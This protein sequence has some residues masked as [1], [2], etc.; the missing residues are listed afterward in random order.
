MDQY[1][2]LLGIAA[3]LF[4]AWALSSNKRLIRPR[5]IIGGVA[6]QFALAWMFLAFPPLVSAF[7]TIASIVNSVIS[8]SAAGIAFLFGE[9]QDPEG[10]WG[11]IFAIQALPIIIYFASLMAI[12]YYVGVMQRVVAA[13]AWVLRRAVGVSGTEA[14][15]MAA[16]VF[17]GQTEAPLCVKPYIDRMTRSQLMTLMVG[18]FATIAG[19]VLAA[20]V[21]LLGGAD[22]DL[23]VAYTRDLMIA[24]VMSAPAALVIAKMLIPDE[25]DAPEESVHAFNPDTG[26]TNLLD[27]AAAGA[28]DGMR[29]A[30][31]VG[32]MLMAFVALIALVNMPL[33][34]LGGQIGVEHLSLQTILGWIFTPV[35]WLMGVV[36]SDCQ[37]VGSFLGEKLVATE[38]VA[39]TSL[40]R[41]MS[42][43]TP[44]IAPRSAHISAYALCGFANFP[45]LAI[46]IGGLSAIAPSRR[47][48]FSQLALRAMV[49]GALASWMTACIAGLFI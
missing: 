17:V 26:A 48:D 33:G 4:V 27:A 13:L 40:A 41:T 8:A 43:E 36:W 38:F 22:E 42:A 5:I 19:S 37:I 18:G 31:N 24:S 12:L 28:T 1:R 30:V 34:A 45:S 14:L 46:Q 10:P 23:R 11:W 20:Y 32:A 25:G 49:G 6:L 16:N 15:A 47:A 35:A 2:G 21:G 44:A 39:Y 9:V 29:L 3:M 7:T